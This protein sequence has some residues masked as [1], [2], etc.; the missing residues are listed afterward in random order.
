M[1]TLIQ[2][3]VV[4]EK[5]PTPNNIPPP[6]TLDEALVIIGGFSNVSKMP[7]YSWST[8][9]FDCVT[10]SKLRT[11]EGSTC[12]NCYALKNFY[13]MPNV[14]AA[15]AR[16]RQALSHPRFVEAFVFA[17]NTSF[18]RGRRTYEKDGMQVP[19]NRFR[20]FDSGDIDSHATLAKIVSIVQQTPHIDHW[21]PTREIGIVKAYLAHFGEFP[22]NLQVRISTPMIG[23]RFGKPPMG[24]PFSTVGVTAKDIKA[25]PAPTQGNECRNCRNCWENVNVDYAQH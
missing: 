24:L 5:M 22:E 18:V 14:K 1:P 25:C 2:T 8:S 4:K 16:R 20:W 6:F 23:E 13:V 9:A 3:K 11:V 15:H 7:W 21:L 12:S 10:G 17:L 19:E